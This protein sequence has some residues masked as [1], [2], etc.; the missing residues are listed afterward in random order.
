MKQ[1]Q[2]NTNQNNK[3]PNSKRKTQPSIPD[4]QLIINEQ[5]F[6]ADRGASIFNQHDG[7]QNPHESVLTANLESSSAEEVTLT[8]DAFFSANL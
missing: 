4:V 7:T 6:P 8:R 3:N 5:S 2:H 1:A